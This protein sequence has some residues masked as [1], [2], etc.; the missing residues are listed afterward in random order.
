MEL[1]LALLALSMLEQLSPKIQ[2][3]FQTGQITPEQQSA[4]LKRYAELLTN[5][6]ASFAGHEW[7]KSDGTPSGSQTPT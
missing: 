3:L 5:S 4:L 7:T 1:Q 6:V 2:A